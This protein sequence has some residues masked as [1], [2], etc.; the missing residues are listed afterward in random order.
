MKKYPAPITKFLS[1][2]STKLA[3][4]ISEAK[5]LT[6][7]NII[8]N[9]SLDHESAKHIQVSHVQKN[10]LRLVVDSPVWATRLRYKQ[11]EIINRFQNYAI[12]KMIRSIYIKISPA[13]HT[14]TTVNKTKNTIHLTTESASQMQIEIE[15]ISDPELKNAL[16]RITRHAK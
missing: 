12:T 11:E 2:K 16:L 10:Q 7:I 13:I 9:Q 1:A 5:R 15:A 3:P 4:L 6:Q 14:G 8:L